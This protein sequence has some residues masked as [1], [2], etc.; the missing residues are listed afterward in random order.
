MLPTHIQHNPAQ[1][2]KLLSAC[3]VRRVR[4]QH[5]SNTTF[6]KLILEG[7]GRYANMLTADMLTGRYAKVHNAD[8]LA[9][10]YA[11]MLTAGRLA[12]RYD[13]VQNAEMLTSRYAN[14]LTA[15][16]L[17][18]RYTDMLNADMLTTP[19]EINLDFGGGG[20]YSSPD[21]RVILG[22]RPERE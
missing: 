19:S 21:H 16:L 18:G 22:S 14:M 5:K 1:H 12:G 11:N 4:C 7:V 2:D 8:M 20:D 15:D 3:W 9:G 13:D 17:T 6:P 10:K